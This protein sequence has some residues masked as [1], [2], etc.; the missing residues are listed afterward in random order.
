MEDV[1]KVAKV[2]KPISSNNSK[3]KTTVSRKVIGR[4]IVTMLVINIIV[5]SFISLVVKQSIAMVEEKYLNEIVENI[6]SNVYQ[7][8][9]EYI[10]VTEVIAKNSTIVTVLQQSDKSNPMKSNFYASSLENEWTNIVNSFGGSII[11]IGICDIEQDSYL[12]HT[13]DVS[14]AD[15]SFKTRPYYSPVLTKKS[16]VTEPYQDAATGSM[17]VTIASVVVDSGNNPLGVVFVDL[18]VGFMSDLI[19]ESNYGESGRSLILDSTNTV[20]AYSDPTYIG[21][22]YS[23]LGI[24]G[25]EITKELANPTGT[26]MEYE[27]R[28]ASR[29]GAVGLIGDLGWKMVTGMDLGEYNEMANTIAYLL[30]LVLVISVLITL[31]ICSITIVHLLKPMEQMNI[32]MQE[33]SKGNLHY[34]V[35][36]ES[37]DEIGELAANMKVT[38]RNL[39]LYIEEIERQLHE[40]GEGNFTVES[41][42]EFI[43]DF[44]NIQEAIGQFRGLIASTLANL[45]C[46]VEQVTLGSDYVATGSQSLAEGSE[47]Q[48]SSIHELNSFISNITVRINDNAEKALHVN[49]SAQ[50]ISKELISSNEKMG[51]M[52]ISMKEIHEKSEGIKKIVKTIEDVAFQTNILA[53]NAAVEAARAGE[54]GKGF[55]VV[56]EEVRNLSGKTSEAVKNTRMLITDTTTAVD[57]GY[58]IAEGTAK[59]LEVVTNDLTSFITTLEEIALASQEQAEA[60]DK[61]NN[62]VSEISNVMQTNSAISEESAATSEELSSQAAVMKESIDQFR[63]SK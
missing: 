40:F 8:V 63:T 28:N 4:M 15:F 38:I 54:A 24:T 23:S 17:V 48:S 32:A 3:R 21:A 51:D 9:K 37:D 10:D 31:V 1:K 43:G 7:T 13:G 26:L 30:V 2:Q 57:S 12:L 55:S 47:R 6:S 14:S 25:E 50:D 53:L 20:L 52:L 45:K 39:A 5:V 27:I 42:L 36:Y 19:V 60:I 33:L 22:D 29:I 35:T 58:A 46:T 56:A 49:Q 11:N 34:E 16:V 61:I 18:S 41:K 44:T 62:G 59:S